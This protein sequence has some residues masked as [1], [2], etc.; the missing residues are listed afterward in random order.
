MTSAPLDQAV[1]VARQVLARLTPDDLARPTPCVSW[2]VA[3]VLNH[4]VGGQ[5]L[6]A[7]MVSGR[8]PQREP[9]DVTG[10]DYLTL[11]DEAT[12]ASVAAFGSPEAQGRTVTLPFGQMP[13]DAFAKVAATDLLAHTWD[14]AKATGQSTELDPELAEML[15]ENARTFVTETFR[16]PDGVAFFAAQQPA[17]DGAGPADRLAA[18]LG[19]S[20]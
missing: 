12:A 14:I 10:A 13:S 8:E 4:V 7:A 20:L 16:G 19:R 18:F 3:G 2:T 15:L 17:P 9:V 5:Q 6:F 11:F 1:G